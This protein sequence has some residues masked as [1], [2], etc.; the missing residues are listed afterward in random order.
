MG[1]EMKAVVKTDRLPGADIINIE[2]PKVEPG[3]VL[4]RINAA[5][6]CGTDLHIYDWNEW[7]QQRVS[8]PMV[9][10][11]EF[12]G[13]IVEVGKGV[14]QVGVGD[15]VAGETHVPC[16]KCYQCKTG[17]QH[18]CK[19]MKILG[20]DMPGVFS[21]YA[22][23]PEIC[24]WK[25]RQDMDPILGALLEPFGVAVHAMFCGDIA[26]KTVGVFGCGPIGLFAVNIARACGASKV[27]AC[28][29]IDERLQVA[30]TMGATHLVNPKEGN[31]IERILDI[32]DGNG[33][34]AGIELSGAPSALN[35]MFAAMTRGGRVSLAGLQSKPPEIDIVN[36]VIYKELR[37]YGVTG[38]I[39]F[40][41]WY[42]ALSLIESG[43]VELHHAIAGQYNLSEF[44]KAMSLAGKGA[45]GKLILVP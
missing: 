17:L 38:R 39:M 34:D 33:L 14:T 15:L 29:V 18:V 32:T 5:A 25:L 30:H 24:A 20:V 23:I 21:E 43:A 16:G 11:H 27:I 44:E 3:H 45:A 19:D 12:C 1:T 35:Q 28:E 42:K 8:P 22:L 26:G 10:G 6:I 41:T 2:V 36:N 7:A 4:V 40:D 9:I 13:E 37:I 31:V